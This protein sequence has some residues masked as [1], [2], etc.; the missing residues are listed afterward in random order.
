MGDQS[1]AFAKKYSQNIELLATSVVGE[2]DGKVAEDFFTGAEECYWEQLGGAAENEITEANGQQ[3]YRQLDHLRR[4]VYTTDLELP[5]MLDKRHSMR[6]AVSFESSYTERTV[7]AYK[8]SKAIE[9]FKGVFNPAFTGKNGTDA[10]AFDYANQT[11]D[12]GLGGGGS[13]DGLNK[14]KLILARQM[15]KQAGYN[16]KDRRYQPMCAVSSAQI[17]DLLNTLEATSADFGKVEALESGERTSWLG[18]EFVIGETVPYMNGSV[19]NLEWIEN[20]KGVR[21]PV[22]ATDSVPFEGDGDNIRAC[23]AYVKDVVG[24]H[25]SQHF[26]TE[27][28]KIERFRYNWGLYASWSHGAVRRQE[29]GVVLIPCDQSAA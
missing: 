13:N 11:I 8:R 24:C 19:V 10:V 17:S 14:E 9:I 28:G 29:D 16:L 12:V 22:D 23:F 21:A 7:E 2:F 5:L 20:A 1:T 18:F 26:E 25:T 15:L 6:S 3:V 27:A 4:M